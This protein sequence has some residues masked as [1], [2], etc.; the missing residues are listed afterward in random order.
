MAQTV[1]DHAAIQ[2][3]WVQSLGQE[4]LLEKEMAPSPVFLP[5]EYHGQRSLVGY[6]P[7]GHKES[8]T[9]KVTNPFTFL[10]ITR[11]R[12]FFLRPP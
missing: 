3:T 12:K 10:G 5:G 7:W 6:D 2:E 8:D 4:D 1:K 11:L 9:T